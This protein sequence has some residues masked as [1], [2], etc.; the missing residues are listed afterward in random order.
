M[1]HP[2]YR[3]SSAHLFSFSFFYYSEIELQ[4]LGLS[5]PTMVGR[6]QAKVQLTLFFAILTFLACLVAPGGKSQW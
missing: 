5:F 2:A 1:T 6:R 3:W 4:S